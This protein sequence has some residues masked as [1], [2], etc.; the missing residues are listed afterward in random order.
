MKN[1]IEPIIQH[2]S[3]TEDVRIKLLNCVRT[4]DEIHTAE[5]NEHD[6]RLGHMRENGKV[7]L[8]TAEELQ[9]LPTEYETIVTDTIFEIVNEYVKLSPILS[10]FENPT[11]DLFHVFYCIM[12]EGDFHTLHNHDSAFTGDDSQ[13]GKLSGTIY[14]DVPDDLKWPQG[15]FN[16]IVK[17]YIN[18]NQEDNVWQRAPQAGDAFLWPSWGIHSVYPFRSNQERIGIGYNCEYR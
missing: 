13:Y 11:F 18:K 16:L 1:T 2:I 7:G 9:R 8:I 4:L 6:S 5:G 3:I 14:L 10:S 17:N 12:K 15:N